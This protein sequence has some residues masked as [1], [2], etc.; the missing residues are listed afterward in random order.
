[1]RATTLNTTLNKMATYKHLFCGILVVLAA[2][3]STCLVPAEGSSSV[4][5]PYC[6]AAEWTVVNQ[7]TGAK[8][9]AGKADCTKDDSNGHLTS[10]LIPGEL[11]LQ[12]QYEAPGQGGTCKGDAVSVTVSGLDSSGKH[13][14]ASSSGFYP[15]SL[16]IGCSLSVQV[17]PNAEQLLPGTLHA[18]LGNCP[19]LGGCAKPSDYD[20]IEVDGSF[21]AY[22]QG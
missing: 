16:G 21:R 6:G 10:I 15:V 3:G 18:V 11:D 7:K 9:F 13:W 5:W 22:Y 1:M 19:V 12:I 17:H 8:I 4:P 20:V 14:G 2:V